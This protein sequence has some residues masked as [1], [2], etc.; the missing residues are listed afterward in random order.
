MR[1]ADETADERAAFAR[2]A[3]RWLAGMRAPVGQVFADLSKV[4]PEAAAE[5]V[6]AARAGDSA[7]TLAA[8]ARQDGSALR[9]L[10]KSAL[11]GGL[12]TLVAVI[13]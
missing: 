9:A 7:A 4:L 3:R 6:F 13:R 2:D 10:V 1:K 12:A 8:L 11:L 5:Q